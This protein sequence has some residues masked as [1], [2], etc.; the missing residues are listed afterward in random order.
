MVV[1]LVAVVLAWHRTGKHGG[2]DRV[3]G[4]EAKMAQWPE[5]EEFLKTLDALDARIKKVEFSE[6]SIVAVGNRLNAFTKDML[7]MKTLLAEHREAL[8]LLRTKNSLRAVGGSH[9]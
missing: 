6:N 5:V 3:R 9:E 2:I 1:A 7:E 4:M 8:A